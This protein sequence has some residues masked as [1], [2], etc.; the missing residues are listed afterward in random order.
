MRQHKKFVIVLGFVLIL[1]VF[2]TLFAWP[3]AYK[4]YSDL[5]AYET[6]VVQ[7][8]N[9]KLYTTPLS[10][11]VIRDICLVLEIGARSE[12]CQ[13]GAVVYAPELFDEIKSYFN[14]LPEEAQTEVMVQEKL[15][16]YLDFCESPDAEGKY[17]C[18][19]DLRGDG[20]Y[21]IAFFFDENGMYYRIIA[22]IG[23]S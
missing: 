11:V 19:F 23:G 3:T 22:N 7:R 5:K 13:S 15:G 20:M 1:L 9:Y 17:V 12:H 14:N 8:D 18:H 21:P 4:I 16:T 10:E 2:F 6:R